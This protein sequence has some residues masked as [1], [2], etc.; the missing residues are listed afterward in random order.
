MSHHFLALIMGTGFNLLLAALVISVAVLSIMTRDSFT[1][2][3][4][5]VAYGL[6]L[7]LVWVRIAAPD[8]ALT[9]AAIGS[10]VT[11]GLLLSGTAR[12]LRTAPAGAYERP[13][14]ALRALA[15]AL[16]VLVAMGLA[17]VVL[18]LPE[19]APTLAPAAAASLS[20]TGLGN[21]VAAVL[22]VYRA[23]DTLLESVVL[24]LALLG[25][26]SLAPDGLWGGRPGL[27]SYVESDS[28]LTLLARFLTPIGIVIGLHIFW[29]GSQAPGGEFQASAI[30]AAMWILAIMAGLVDA[31]AV[32]RTWLRM[33]L[34]FGPIVFMGIGFVGFAIAGGF[35]AYPPNA[36]KLLILCIE[37]ALM[38]SIAVMLG[39]L[40]VG[41]PAR[42]ERP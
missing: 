18:L 27:T 3:V 6:L 32:T 16:C 10:G 37:I 22:V 17:G 34:V 26:W 19:P 20:A 9:E 7:A 39:L 4:A 5:Y 28:A 25:V 15:A 40:V 42:Q 30:L 13:G 8:V 11:G 36:A 14:P 41:G 29:V 35:L 23:V 24:V 38:L 2:V 12:L 33:L 21:P 31:P 1:S